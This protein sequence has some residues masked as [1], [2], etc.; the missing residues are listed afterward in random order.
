MAE[1]ASD[2]YNHNEELI[3]CENCQEEYEIDVWVSYVGGYIEIQNLPEATEIILSKTYEQ[4]EEDS[5]Y[6]DQVEAIE[7]NREFFTTFQAEIEN[8]I[9]LNEVNLNDAS[10]NRSLKNQLLVASI[11]VME[12]FLSDT[13]INLTLS[14]TN[15]VRRFITS[16][17]EFKKQKFEISEIYNQMENINA[18]A[19]KTMLDVIYH[20]LPKVSNMYKKT[21]EINFPSISEPMKLVSKRHDLVHRNGKTKEGAPFYLSKSEIDECLKTIKSFITDVTNELKLKYTMDNPF[22]V[23]DLL[24]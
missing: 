14:D 6:E 9:K 21:F 8:I 16:F 24:F 11:T 15:L 4:V 10:L 3:V 5:Y 17:P 1:K 22:N 2:S 12:T 20:D 7:S 19:K 23:G 13:F 18:T